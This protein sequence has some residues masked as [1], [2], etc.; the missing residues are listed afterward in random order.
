MEVVDCYDKS[1]V[2]TVKEAQDFAKHLE[3]G[4]KLTSDKH[5][6]GHLRVELERES[7]SILMLQ[8]TSNGLIQLFQTARCSIN[9]R[10]SLTP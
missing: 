5:F 8:L 3:V 4:L 9:E 6:R 1:D 2:A 10:I 7:L